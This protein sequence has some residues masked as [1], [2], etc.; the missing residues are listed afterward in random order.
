VFADDRYLRLDGRPVF[1]VYRASRLP[2]PLRTTDAWR[3]VC[4]DEGVGE[5]MLLRVESLV[6]ET[7]DPRPMGFDAAIEFPPDWRL[8]RGGLRRTL[9]WRLLRRAHVSS[10]A[11]ARHRVHDY[12]AFARRTMGE[13]A[14]PYPRFPGVT[15]SWD[16]S[17]RR[18]NGAV[19][20]R[21]P[22]PAVYEAWLDAALARAATEA[23][24]PWVFVNAWNEWAEGNV[25]EPTRD[26]GHAFLDGTKRAVARARSR[27]SVASAAR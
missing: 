15:P 14:E 20:L 4:S 2:D 8:L 7:G 10:E 11:F 19:I 16:N 25:L 24:G 12:S 9:P 21:D 26:L 22:S 1:A 23:P 13:P 6:D 27:Q 3:K 5:L 17:P 18:A